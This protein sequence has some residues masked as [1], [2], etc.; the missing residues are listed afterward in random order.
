MVV[1]K[2]TT[3]VQQQWNRESAIGRSSGLP[4]APEFL[5]EDEVEQEAERARMRVLSDIASHGLDRNVQ[6]LE[7]NGY[8]VLEPGQVGSPSLID[9]LRDTVLRISEDR[10]ARPIDVATGAS[11]GTLKSPFGQVQPEFTLLTQDPIFEQAL[12]NSSQLALITYLLGESCIL[13]HLSSF[14]KGPGSE[15]LPLHA[16]QNQTGSIAP[17]PAYAQVA[18]AT[19]ALTDYTGENGAICFVPG[20]HKLC[21]SPTYAEATDARYF[22]PLEAPAGSMIVWHGNTWHGA[23]PRVNQGLRISLVVYFNRWYHPPVDDLTP[24]ITREM[25][26]RNGPRFALLTRMQH[27]NLSPGG[28]VDDEAR[29][30]RRASKVGLFS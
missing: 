18:N 6:Q 9:K 3:R 21:R 19:W 24:Y 13:N 28:N 27:Y 29:L 23:V 7:T 14:V 15:Y 30:R 17:Y 2:Q 10:L 12:M 22:V 5:V 25:L 8:T 4:F 1:K 26:E 16:D 20:S 11:H